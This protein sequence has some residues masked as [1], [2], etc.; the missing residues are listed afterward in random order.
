MKKRKVVLDVC[1]LTYIKR[2]Y[3]SDDCRKYVFDVCNLTYIKRLMY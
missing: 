3:R 2:I 1:N